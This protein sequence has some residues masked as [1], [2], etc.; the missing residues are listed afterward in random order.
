MPFNAFPVPLCPS[1]S[2]LIDTLLRSHTVLLSAALLS[3]V[4]CSPPNPLSPP[5]C[6]ID[7]S[8]VASL[9]MLGM[10]IFFVAGSL[11]AIIFA[12]PWFALALVPTGAIYVYINRYF[13]N[14]A[15][16]IVSRSTERQQLLLFSWRRQ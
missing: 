15:R 10:C 6:S 4:C 13:R 11:A 12:T 5:A 14:A 3:A 1:A 16:E 2:F 7:T 8:L 9:G